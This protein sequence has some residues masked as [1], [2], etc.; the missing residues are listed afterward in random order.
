M[1]GG[2]IFLRQ[3]SGRCFSWEKIYRGVTFQGTFSGDI[4]PEIIFLGVIFPTAFYDELVI[5]WFLHVRLAK[6]LLVPH[7]FLFSLS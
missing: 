5:T 7:I 4:F 3:F 1:G 6:I 2:A